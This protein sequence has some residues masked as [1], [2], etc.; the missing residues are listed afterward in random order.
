MPFARI[1]NGPDTCGV[2]KSNSMHFSPDSVQNFPGNANATIMIKE[3]EN[4]FDEM[5]SN[6]IKMHGA[7]KQNLFWKQHQVLFIKSVFR[8]TYILYIYVHIL[9]I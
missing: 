2:Y 5:Q 4:F 9:F 7:D 3:S 8:E 6:G 1:P